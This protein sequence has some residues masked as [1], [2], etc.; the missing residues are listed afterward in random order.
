M[1][2]GNVPITNAMQYTFEIFMTLDVN[3]GTGY[4]GGEAYQSGVSVDPLDVDFE[5]DIAAITGINE[6]TLSNVSVSPN[7]ASNVL[8]IVTDEQIQKV[9]I[10]SIN[11]YSSK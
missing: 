7:P 4:A 1:I 10:Y 9:E 3:A 11:G 2:T 8:N 6:I 5:V